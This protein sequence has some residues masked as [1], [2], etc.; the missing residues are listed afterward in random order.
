M[1]FQDE[2]FKKIRLSAC[3]KPG[4]PKLTV[5]ALYRQPEEIVPESSAGIVWDDPPSASMAPPPIPP[6]TAS[7]ATETKKRGRPSNA[8]LAA[9]EPSHAPLQKRSSNRLNTK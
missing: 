8:E 2:V 3:R 5:G 9:R 1:N 7:V 4:R 6:L